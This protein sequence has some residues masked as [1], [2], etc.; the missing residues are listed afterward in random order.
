MPAFDQC[1]CILGYDHDV[2]VAGEFIHPT[3]P[4]VVTSALFSRRHLTDTHEEYK[5]VGYASNRIIFEG[6][7]WTKEHGGTGFCLSSIN[8]T[9]ETKS[10]ISN[11]E[12]SFNPRIV[13]QY[14]YVRSKPLYRIFERLMGLTRVLQTT[15]KS[16]F[17]AKK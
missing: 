10:G 8:L 17:N 1:V 9:D 15:F 14:N 5:R 7:V 16:Y 2:P 13:P 11:F 3:L 6:C 12:L 4:V